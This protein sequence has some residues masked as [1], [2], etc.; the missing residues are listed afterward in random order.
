VSTRRR[1][2]RLAAPALALGLLAGGGAWW[3]WWRT[4]AGLRLDV[5]ACE[6]LAEGGGQLRLR[7]KNQ[8]G[9]PQPFLADAGQR[10]WPVLVVG[11]HPANAATNP[12][13]GTAVLAPGT[14][15]EFIQRVPRLDTRCQVSLMTYPPD[16]WAWVRRQAKRLP[17]RWAQLLLYRG[18]PVS[19]RWVEPGEFRAP[20]VGDRTPDVTRK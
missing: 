19:S 20:G 1:V 11:E 10:P 2:R 5:V 17:A 18:R 13:T 12:P 8:T 14:T 15:L 6:R 16:R 4:H 7:L 9:Q 3:S